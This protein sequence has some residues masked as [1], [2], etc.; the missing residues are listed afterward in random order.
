MNDDEINEIIARSDEEQVIFH[1]IDLQRERDTLENWRRAGNRGKPPPPL[2]QLEELPECYRADEPFAEPDAIDEMEGRGHRRRTVVNYNDGLSDDQWAMVSGLSV[3]SWSARL[4][5][6]SKA[7]EDGED[8][9][10]LSARALEK[11]ERRAASKIVR[12]AESVGSPAPEI[13]TPRNRKGKKGKAKMPEFE[14]TP[15]SSKRKRGGG[16][17][18]SM[19]PSLMDDDDEERDTVSALHLLS[20]YG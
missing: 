20:S 2:M 4:R 7:L 12:E 8:I 19:T 14:A 15:A 6:R 1:E 5:P 16:K 17:S 18:T 13:D 9:Q 3:Q 11:K 10:E